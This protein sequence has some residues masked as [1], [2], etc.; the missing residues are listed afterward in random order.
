M[1]DDID[2]DGVKRGGDADSER[3]DGFD[4]TDNDVCASSDDC[5]DDCVDSD[6]MGK[7]D[8]DRDVDVE[9]ASVDVVIFTL[10]DIDDNLKTAEADNI[11]IALD[12]D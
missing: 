11:R 3:N 2:T 9:A 7:P 10:T 1:E 4:D 5:T 8:S 12:D 6:V